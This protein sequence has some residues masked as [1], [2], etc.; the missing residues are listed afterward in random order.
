MEGY[1]FVFTFHNQNK[2][3][4]ENY[5]TNKFTVNIKFDYFCWTLTL[6]YN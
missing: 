1:P 5:K 2:A 3:E 4:Y 6:Y